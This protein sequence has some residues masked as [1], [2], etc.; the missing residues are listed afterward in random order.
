M[1]SLQLLV[2]VPAW[3]LLVAAS[4]SPSPL[5]TTTPVPTPTPLGANIV[6]DSAAGGPSITITVSGSSFLAGEHMNLFWDNPSHVA[7][8]VTTDG[9]GSFTKAVH[10]FPG[11]GPAAHRLCVSVPP[12]P[13]ANFT[14]QGPPTPTPPAAPSPSVAAAPSPTPSPTSSASASRLA[15]S[16]KS[17]TGGLDVITKPPLVFLPI[18]GLLG[19]LAALAYWMLMRVDR[20]ERLPVLPTATVVHKSARP[21]IERPAARSGGST[22]ALD[23]EPPPTDEAPKPTPY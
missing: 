8:D 20:T 1:R 4:P 21:N 7:A 9:N 10:P 14:L 22:S 16:T 15:L 18:I 19:L 13:C 11:D 3:L 6:L 5:A 17:G 2:V 12:G 23:A